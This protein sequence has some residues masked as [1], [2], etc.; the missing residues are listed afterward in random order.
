MP[1]PPGNSAHRFLGAKS[2]GR[3]G[4]LL[5]R[6]AIRYVARAMTIEST[7]T[8]ALHE[9]AT[10]TFGRHLRQTLRLALPVVIARA[11][12][13]IMVTVDTAMVGHYDTVELAAFA[14]G[15]AVQIIMILVGVGLLQGTVIM[16]SQAHGAGA[17]ADCG[18]HW[19]VS[20]LNGAVM[21]VI[22]GALCLLGEP[23]LTLFGQLPAVAERGGDVLRMVS[24][25]MPAMMLWVAT[26]FFLEGISRPLPGMTLM[27]AAVLI[28]AGLNMVF[29]Y[30]HLG[31]PAMGAEGA[32]VATSI[33]RWTMF[34]ALAGY[35]L[36]MR[37]GAR[38][39]V[40]GALRE[41]W[42]AGKKLRRIGYPLG[43]ARGL[44]G[45][46]FSALTI[47]A[48]LLGTV[49]LAGYQIAF[50][51]IGLI[52][53]CAIGTAAAST[54]RVGNAVGRASGKDIRRAGWAGV[55][56][57]FG[58]MLAFAG[59]FLGLGDPLAH[60]YSDDPTVLPMATTLIGIGG[61]VLVFDGAQAVLMGALRG[62]AD[63]WIPPV[64]QFLAWWGVAVPMAYGLAFALGVGVNGLMWAFLT[65]AI[66][67]ST[68][69][70]LRFHVVARRPPRRY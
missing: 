9:I 25:G 10:M 27:M 43:A 37:D 70:S 32:A 39:G 18:R 69:L 28:N 7:A 53:M 34:A 4:A 30:G 29:I 17:Y 67:S 60:I 33:V 45:G 42:T 52:F 22:I 8:G 40:R 65:G 36:T 26:S 21:G 1:T 68:L 24:W 31:V 3:S 41:A 12:L 15:N 44:E 51:L 63:V 6:A 56:I 20:L 66:V 5:G 35:V 23:L 62:L 46:A 50:N 58:V 47:L 38:L 61:L 57:I 2:W 13:L 59:I 16:V 54:I 14:A 55:L 48:G 11:G 64:L 49:Q 19:R